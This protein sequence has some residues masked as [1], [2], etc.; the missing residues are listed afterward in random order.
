MAKVPGFYEFM[1]DEAIKVFVCTNWT[2]IDAP[3]IEFKWKE[4]MPEEHKVKSRPIAPQRFPMVQKEFG[5][6]TQY[7]LLPCESPF[8]SPMSDADKATAPFVRICGDYRFVNQFIL[9]DQ[10]HIPKIQ[11]ELL[12]FK[13][14]RYFADLDMV[15]SFHQFRLGFLTSQRLSIITPFGTYRPVFLPE[16]VSPAT[17]ILHSRMRDI[18]ADFSEWSVVIFDNF[19]IGG[20]SH[21]DLFAKLK[22]FVARCK[23][24]NIFLLDIEYIHIIL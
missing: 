12:R 18:F 2:G 9:P 8:V 16:G 4:G 23:E 13:G 14:F 19:C 11:Y 22:L 3:P 1:R 7:H 21:E 5:R 15:N 20:H 17:G 10:H 6:L 24:Y